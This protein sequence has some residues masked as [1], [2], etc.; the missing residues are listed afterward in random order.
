MNKQKLINPE[1]KNKCLCFNLKKI[2]KG[3][4]YPFLEY[5]YERNQIFCLAK[6]KFSDEDKLHQQMLY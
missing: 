3:I 2:S 6:V 5:L 4:N 1:K